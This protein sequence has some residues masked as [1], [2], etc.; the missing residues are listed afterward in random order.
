MSLNYS[1]MSSVR[2]HSFA[3]EKLC[4]A[5]MA[6]IIDH[7]EVKLAGA[8]T[9]S[10]LIGID[11]VY[12]VVFY[13]DSSRKRL[14]DSQAGDVP[15]SYLVVRNN[16]LVLNRYLIVYAEKSKRKLNEEQQDELPR[17]ALYKLS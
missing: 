16:D 1:S 6:E 10:S 12:I 7:P 11:I 3:G 17:L 13:S 2:D 8:G 9:K 4:C 14:A 5:V 15:E